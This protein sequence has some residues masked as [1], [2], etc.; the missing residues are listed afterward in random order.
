[1]YVEEGLNKQVFELFLIFSRLE[2]A[3]TRVSGFARGAD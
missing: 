2:Y 3:L 1:M